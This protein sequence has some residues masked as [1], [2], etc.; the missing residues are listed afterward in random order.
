M[1][2]IIAAA[3]ALFFS[4]SVAFA[5][6][7]DV[8]GAADYPGLGR[9]GGSVI[10][11]YEAQDFDDAVI[12]AAAFSGGKAADARTV[13]GRVVRIAYRTG[14]G[15]ST[16]EVMRNFRDKALGAGFEK[17]LE[18]ETDACGGMDFAGGV[19]VLPIPS[20]WFDGFNYRYFSAKKPA[21]ATGGETYLAVAVSQNNDDIYAQVTV[22]E[23]GAMSDKMI[24]AAAMAKGLA[25]TGRIA[26]YGIY[27]DTAKAEVK[28]QSRPTLEQIAQLLADNS[29]LATV[30]IVGHTDSQGA[31]DYNMDLSKRRAEAIAAELAANYGVA[32]A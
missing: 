5:D 19:E 25:E 9:F 24:D 17:L 2:R 10:T 16:L 21:G 4:A 29:Q 31:Y 6:A 15:A 12:Q 7:G 13:E 27:F 23:T 18:C 26:L 20:M 28:P 30:Y 11:G 14:A 1:F 8:D 22:V 32:R 3:A